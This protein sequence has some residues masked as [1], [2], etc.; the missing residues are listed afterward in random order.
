[1]LTSKLGAKEVVLTEFGEDGISIENDVDDKRLLPTALI[2]NLRYAVAM[3]NCENV[4]VCHLDWYD[5]LPNSLSSRGENKKFNNFDLIIGSDLLNWTDDAFPLYSTLKYL[6]KTNPNVKFLLCLPKNNREGVP[7][8]VEM[9]QEDK[10]FSQIDI[11]EHCLIHFDEEYI[12]L[13]ITLS[14]AV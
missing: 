1:L 3:N 14:N 12:T 9:I 10:Y 4:N 8:L 13:F 11:E 2:S 6:D 5:Y 7:K